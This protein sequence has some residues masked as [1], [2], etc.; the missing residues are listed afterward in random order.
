M[1]WAPVMGVEVG[2]EGAEALLGWGEGC[3]SGWGEGADGLA[4]SGR[5]RSGGCSAQ[6]HLLCRL[7][8]CEGLRVSHRFGK[9]KTD[10]ALRFY[11]HPRR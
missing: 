1:V 6:E 7:R 9:G 5:F 2:V 10:N 3:G 8:R 11:R 4:A